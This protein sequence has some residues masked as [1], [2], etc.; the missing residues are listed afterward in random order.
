MEIVRDFNPNEASV[1][2]NKNEAIVPSKDYVDL[3]QSDLAIIDATLKRVYDTFSKPEYIKAAFLRNAK[4][5]YET[6]AMYSRR[7]A[8]EAYNSMSWLGRKI[9]ERKWM[10]LEYN[11]FCE[12]MGIDIMT[13][14][15]FESQ[16]AENYIRR[17]YGEGVT[18][19]DAIAVTMEWYKSPFEMA[20]RLSPFS[21]QVS[22]LNELDSKLKATLTIVELTVENTFY[23]LQTKTD[24]IGYV[25]SLTDRLNSHIENWEFDLKS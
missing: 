6:Y 20:Y 14:E 7:V 25:K 8:E 2:L 3:I 19:D 12:Y 11:D 5:S 22:R 21:D 1:I 15:E 16:A 17:Q 13:P 18:I 4:G 10:R 23:H 24:E 9:Y